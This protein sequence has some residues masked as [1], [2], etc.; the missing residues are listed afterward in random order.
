MSESNMTCTYCNFKGRFRDIRGHLRKKHNLYSYV[1]C[2][3]NTC[4]FF[5]A[6]DF[7]CFKTHSARVHEEFFNGRNTNLGDGKYFKLVTMGDKIKQN[8]HSRNC[9]HETEVEGK[10]KKKEIRLRNVAEKSILARFELITPEV[11]VDTSDA[12]Q[13]YFEVLEDIKK[14]KEEYPRVLNKFFHES[15]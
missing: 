14:L 2:K 10:K 13:R 1:Q 11:R 4:S 3:Q 15:L 6:K 12:S 9:K 5:C 8:I 7:K